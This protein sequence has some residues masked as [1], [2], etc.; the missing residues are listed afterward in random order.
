MLGIGG[1]F[2]AHVPAHAILNCSRRLVGSGWSR[3]FPN[4]AR[5]EADLGLAQIVPF[6]TGGVRKT[7]AIEHV[8][9]E[10]P[11]LTCYGPPA[12]RFE[13]SHRPAKTVTDPARGASFGRLGIRGGLCLLEHAAD[14]VGG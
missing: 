14:G 7:K 9:T 11:R 1:R 3:V 10:D 12:T 13:R 2:R 6:L 5:Q 8:P 4:R